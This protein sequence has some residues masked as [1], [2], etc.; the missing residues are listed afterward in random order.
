MAVFYRVLQNRLSFAVKATELQRIISFRCKFTKSRI[1][2]EIFE[3]RS[4]E[5]NKYGGDPEQPHQLHLITRVKS[6]IRR[7]YWEKKIVQ[8]LGLEKAH[9]V[10][11]HKNIPSIND[12]LKIIKHLVKIQPLKLP[13]GLPSEE[14][15]ADTLLKSNGELVV[16]RLLKPLEPKAIES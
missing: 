10:Y 16:R 5:H 2:P 7:P 3:E 8:D 12:K 4:K 9:K 6:T 14:D 1:P 15:L 11:I 13:H